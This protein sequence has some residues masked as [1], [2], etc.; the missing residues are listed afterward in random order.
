MGTGLFEEYRT[1]AA[2]KRMI[3]YLI[4]ELGG[5]VRVTYATCTA[6][7]SSHSAQFS[8]ALSLAP[9]TTTT[10]TTQQGCDY[11]EPAAAMQR[12]VPAVRAKWPA[13]ADIELGSPA[14]LNGRCVSSYG[15]LFCKY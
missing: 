3:T 8:S 7:L 9:N 10:T 1:R 2:C 4:A 14:L 11:K 13:A 5:A 6:R 15:G 12:V